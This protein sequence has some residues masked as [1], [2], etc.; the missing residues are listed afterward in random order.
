[1]RLS[2]ALDDGSHNVLDAQRFNAKAQNR[3]FLFVK[4][5]ERALIVI[6]ELSKLFQSAQNGYSS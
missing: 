3:H 6:I 1:M 5:V 4:K 2:Q